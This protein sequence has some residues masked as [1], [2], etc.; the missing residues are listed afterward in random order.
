M[1]WPST[2]VAAGGQVKSQSSG[3]NELLII[4]VFVSQTHTHAGWM[5]THIQ[6][7]LSAKLIGAQNVLVPGLILELWNLFF[8]YML[9]LNTRLINIVYC[10]PTHVGYYFIKFT[11]RCEGCM[12]YICALKREAGE[13]W[14]KREKKRELGLSL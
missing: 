2:H 9:Q 6:C 7:A 11:V 5:C 3:P 13:K 8:F 1:C 12:V 14:K 10:R 4:C